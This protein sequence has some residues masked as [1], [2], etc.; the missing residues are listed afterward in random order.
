MAKVA[1]SNF[2]AVYYIPLL[3]TVSEVGR[4]VRSLSQNPGLKDMPPFV[5]SKAFTDLLENLFHLH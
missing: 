4:P 5:A 1:L 3:Q 2:A